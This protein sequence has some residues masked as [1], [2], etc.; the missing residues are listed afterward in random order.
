MTPQRP[1]VVVASTKPRLLAAGILAYLLAAIGTGFT[2]TGTRGPRWSR[3][4][5]S[6]SPWRRAFL[7]AWAC[8]SYCA[9]VLKK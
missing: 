7:P 6:G 5:L 3:S 1:A 9:F 4:I 2:G 8:G